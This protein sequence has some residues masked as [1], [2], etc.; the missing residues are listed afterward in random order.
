MKNVNR[1][2]SSRKTSFSTNP[3]VVGVRSSF[4]IFWV[5][6]TVAVGLLIASLCWLLTHAD[7][8]FPG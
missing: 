4:W 3:L 6:C 7:G 5:G 1:Y 8:R 2:E